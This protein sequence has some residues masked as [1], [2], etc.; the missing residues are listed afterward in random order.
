[1][2]YGVSRKSARVNVTM[3]DV[4]H[5][6]LWRMSLDLIEV[7]RALREEEKRWQWFCTIVACMTGTIGF[8]VGL[9]VAHV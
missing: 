6:K 7:G 5:G 4:G 9:V 1:V 3:V 2:V 8:I